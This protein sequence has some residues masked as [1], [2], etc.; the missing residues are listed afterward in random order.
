MQ[1]QYLTFTPD[2]V[3]DFAKI[4]QFLLEFTV[5]SGKNSEKKYV[6]MMQRISNREQ[7]LMEILTEDLESWFTDKDYKDLL[8]SILQN[9][10]RYINIFYEAVDLLLPIPS[11]KLSPDDEMKDKDQIIMYQRS[12]N[13]A[14]KVNKKTE[15]ITMQ[16]LNNESIPKELLRSYELIIVPGK[17]S[18]SKLQRMRE[19]RS[20]QIGSL[21]QVRGTVVRTSDVKPYIRV[22]TYTC[23]LCGH[24]IYQ[25]ISGKTFMP[26]TECTSVQCRN[27]NSQGKVYPLNRTSKFVSFQEIKI[28]EPT[29]EVPVGNVPRSITIYAFGHNVRQCGPG[30]SIIVDGIFLPSI[31]TGAMRFGKSRLI[32]DTYIEAFKITKEK[33]THT[34]TEEEKLRDLQEAKEYMQSFNKKE[35]KKGKSKRKEEE[36]KADP[37]EVLAKS[38]APEIYG[39]EDV[40][41]ALLLQLIG[42]VDKEM[43]DGMKI[44]GN[45]NILLMGDPGI[46]KSQLL[47]YI[48]HLS[49]RGVYTT[50]KGSSGVGLTAAVVKDTLTNDFVLE[51]GAL[52]LADM[53]ICCIDEFDKMSDYDRA[54][55]HEVMEQQTVSI[56]KA[57]I[58]ARLNA[59]TSVLAAA[60]PLYGRYNPNLSP[61][62]NINLPAALLSRFD[63][64]FLLLDKADK[65]KDRRLAEHVVRV[66]KDKMAPKE[67]FDVI[68]ENKLRAIIANAK[69]YTPIIPQNLHNFIVGKYV[70]KRKDDL[71]V[72]KHGYQYITPR[73]LLA[74]LRLAQALAKLKMCREVKQEHVDEALRLV[75]A[76]KASVEGEQEKKAP[77]IKTDP[78]SL[79][80]NIVRDACLAKSDHTVKFKEMEEK[81]VRETKQSKKQF[82]DMIQEYVNLN[83]LYLD[84]SGKEITFL[85]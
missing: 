25:I 65:E 9:T 55:I 26:I 81:V 6:D 50:G 66:H 15:D 71:K 19:L 45:L 24:E 32:H 37:Y 77:I 16:D 11:K 14:A 28:Q 83:I 42:G 72:E 10:K 34:Q 47:K 35:N 78:K 70:E 60:N 27:N 3:G 18:K 64:I 73:S 21:I 36:S 7:N 53:G 48:S 68:P 54:N 80:F 23:D 67:D 1:K 33:K 75:E 13:I 82:K 31:I 69:N 22:A 40:K 2:F 38:I 59:R 8:K 41:K 84:E 76:G 61:H 57:G 39:M 29:S 49:P 43:E 20:I 63:L 30:D 85:M 79:M 52:V 51:G 46:A 12:H 56:A 4:K 5:S 58:T 17:E 62:E 74:V 44:R